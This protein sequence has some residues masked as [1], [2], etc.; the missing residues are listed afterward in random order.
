M[1]L[2]P[3]PRWA[4]LGPGP[5]LPDE[6]RER[7]GQA[8]ASHGY[9]RPQR[10]RD[11][12]RPAGKSRHQYY[13]T[14]YYYYYGKSVLA[15]VVIFLPIVIVLMMMVMVRMMMLSMMMVIVRRY[16]IYSDG[17]DHNNQ[18]IVIK[19][20]IIIVKIAIKHTWCINLN[21][22][23]ST[24]L[25]KHNCYSLVEKTLFFIILYYW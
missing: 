8:C 18:V 1:R 25:G 16:Q 15:A 23:R 12:A 21:M 4:P 9:P 5:N 20:S 13:Y 2:Y 3:A 10:R 11:G 17:Y 19:S 7:S 22:K 6:R 14:E 24:V